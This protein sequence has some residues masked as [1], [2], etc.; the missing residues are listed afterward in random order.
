M[1]V[2]DWN[3]IFVW[4]GRHHLILV[5]LIVGNAI[6]AEAMPLCFERLTNPIIAIVVSA[7]AFLIFGE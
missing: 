2:D 6:A 1:I 5:S 7:T 4:F 3:M